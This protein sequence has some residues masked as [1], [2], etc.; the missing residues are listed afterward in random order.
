MFLT[1]CS[2]SFFMS[3]FLLASLRTFSVSPPGKGACHDWQS[4]ISFCQ[5]ERAKGIPRRNH[6][7]VWQFGAAFFA[8]LDWQT[9][10]V[11]VVGVILGNSGG[12]H[13]WDFSFNGCGPAGSLQLHLDADWPY[14]ARSIYQAANYGGSITAVLINTPGTPSAAAT[15]FDGY[16]LTQ[17]GKAG[18]A[19]SI[20]LLTSP[21]SAEFLPPSFLFCSAC[22]LPVLP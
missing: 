5:S 8:L 11:M 4:V 13:A 16:P 9:I 18:K 21:A 12:G 14:P 6:G 20:A 19:L 1:W 7:S 3:S 15:C 22:L 17:Q 10:L 2:T